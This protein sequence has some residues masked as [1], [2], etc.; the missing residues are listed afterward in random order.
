MTH[1]EL[2]ATRRNDSREFAALARVLVVGRA[3]KIT[4][5][6]RARV[7][8]PRS[9]GGGR[10]SERARVGAPRINVALLS[11]S[12]ASLETAR[13]RRHAERAEETREGNA[14]ELVRRSRPFPTARA[15][16]NTN[17]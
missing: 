2:M 6:L 12:L 13:V 5:Q 4:V 3:P 14:L 8:T 11:H 9:G 16:N 10:A 15:T 1:P 17:F 7:H